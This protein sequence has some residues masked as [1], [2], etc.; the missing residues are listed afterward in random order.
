M[1]LSSSRSTLAYLSSASALFFA[2]PA[3]AQT[4]LDAS[5]VGD[6]I[7]VTANRTAQK[8]SDVAA[9]VEVITGERLDSTASNSFVDQIKK[10][11]SLDVIQYPNGLAGISLRGL[12]PDFEFT[13]N[14]RTLVLVDGRPSGS[15]SFTTVSPES[16]ERVEVLKGPASA[17]YGASAIGGVV[18][19]ITKHSK[20]QIGGKASIGYGSFDTLRADLA[21]GGSIS[22]RTDFDLGIG[23]V[24]QFDDFSAGNGEKRPNSDFRRLSGKLRFGADLADIVRADISVDGADLH[25]NAPGPLSFNPQSRSANHTWRFGGD[26]RIEITPQD[27]DVLLLGYASKEMYKDYEVPV[28]S[29]RYQSSQTVTRYYGA[30]LQDSWKVLT[31]L[32]LTYGFDWQRVEAD[33]LS[34][35]ADGSRKAPYSP[36]ETRTTKALFAEAVLSL[37][38]NRLILTAGGRNDW[39]T[40]RS[41]DTPLKTN[42]TPGAAKFSVFS[43]RGGIVFK[44]NNNLRL[45]GTVGRAFVPAQAVQLAG[46]TEEFAGAQRRLT[47]GNPDLKPERN[48]SWDLGA[49][50][51]GRWLAADVTYFHSDTDDKIESVIVSETPTLRQ[52]SYVNAD[53]SKIRGIEG[54]ISIDAGQAA[55]LPADRFLLVSSITHILKA[56]ENLPAGLTAIRNVADWKAN[57]SLTISDGNALS[58]TATVRYNGGR[59]DTDNSQGK[60]FTSGRGGVFEY[61]DA[62]VVDLSARWKV[63]QHD[64][65]RAEI[66]NLFGV[67]YYEKADYAMPGRS[68]SVRY[69]RSF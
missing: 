63:T 12:R 16:I 39:I 6:D 47:T 21:T 55:G 62:T 42:F 7:I 28:S 41:L 22:D 50:Y 69:S 45:H 49:G 31:P 68:F 60:I 46:E 65:L 24:N 34:F 9:S 59:Y 61:D 40:A 25:N 11:A 20:G 64:Q 32:T 26:G 10:T 17:L 27:H 15:S 13:I 67:N 18:N 30:Q 48:T 37:I 36:N 56:K 66:S 43:P 14:P 53:T 51:A 35:N 38:D 3:Q 5:A 1:K 8:A 54:Q 33:R 52:S 4:V 57:V 2:H 29:P 58:A 19:I 44:I 23:Y